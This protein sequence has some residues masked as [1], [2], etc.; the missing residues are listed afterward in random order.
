M[1][2]LQGHPGAE[3]AGPFIWNRPRALLGVTSAVGQGRP[4]RAGLWDG[5][6][7]LCKSLVSGGHQ[8]VRLRESPAPD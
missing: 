3:G 7:E 5:G 2:S 4:E 6:Q 8:A 1:S